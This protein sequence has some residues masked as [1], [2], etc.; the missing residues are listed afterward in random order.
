[1]T[2][3]E[4]TRMLEQMERVERFFLQYG[5][6]PQ[7]INERNR[8]LFGQR[9]T[10]LYQENYYRVDQAEF[11]G[12]PFLIIDCIDDPKYAGVGVME[13]VGALPV[14]L[15]EEQLEKEVRYALGIE[16]YPENY[17]EW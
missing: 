15:T 5:A 17:P 9:Q 6:V 1:M 8:E 4:S 10:F 14:S 16:P 2:A 13:D 12:T 11:D 3:E 7:Q